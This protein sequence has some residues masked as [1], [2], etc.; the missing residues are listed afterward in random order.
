MRQT[1][2]ISVIKERVG[3]DGQRRLLAV[4]GQVPVTLRPIVDSCSLHRIPVGIGDLSRSTTRPARHRSLRH[5]T[6]S[7]GNIFSEATAVGARRAAST[8]AP[9]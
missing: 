2:L 3:L 5:D 6:N 9:A 8:L 4:M 1:S 7:S